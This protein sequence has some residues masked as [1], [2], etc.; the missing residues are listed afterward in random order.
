M[1]FCTA[2]NIEEARFLS[3]GLLQESLVA[4]ASIFNPVESWFVWKDQIEEVQEV[5]L[6]LKTTDE[7]FNEVQAWILQNHSYEVPEILAINVEKGLESYMKWTIQ[8]V[9]NT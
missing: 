6:I 8:S 9:E 4:C 3:R 7:K 2:K 5:Q 1:V